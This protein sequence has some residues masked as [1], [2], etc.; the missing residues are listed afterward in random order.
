MDI[1]YYKKINNSYNTSFKKD[2]KIYQVK[3]TIERKFEDN[4]FTYLVEVNGKSMSVIISSSTKS[5]RKTIISKPSE[6]FKDGDLVVWEG[7]TWIIT[8]CDP[9]EDI[10]SKGLILLCS[11][12]LKWIDEMGKVKEAPFAIT[13]D[14]LTNFG[15]DFGRI[16]NLPDERRNIV[17]PSTIETDMIKKEDRF[18]FDERAWK[19]TAIN[20]LDTG[21]NYITLNED[22]ID[23]SSDNIEMRIANYYEKKHEVIIKILDKPESGILSIEK[24]QTFKLNI[25]I[26][27]NGTVID[28]ALASVTISDHDI[29]VIDGNMILTPINKGIVVVTVAYENSVDSIQIN[30]TDSIINNYNVSILGDVDIKYSMVKT[31]S[32]KFTNN[33]VSRDEESYFWLTGEDGLST[34]LATITEQDQKQNTCKIKAGSKRGIVVLHVENQSKLAHSEMKIEIKSLL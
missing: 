1:N 3:K 17:I 21:L 33:G 31:Y 25:D 16:I 11:S 18:I 19:V 32:C 10:Y 8:E 28:P 4:L 24:N 20:K 2:A 34:N 6:S 12:T 29:A 14:N 9:R 23:E 26:R 27:S 22:L 30:V 15:V 13:N 7:D 5:N